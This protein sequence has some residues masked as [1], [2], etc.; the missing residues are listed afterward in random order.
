MLNYFVSRCNKSGFVGLEKVASSPPVI[1]GAEMILFF[2]PLSV[3][4]FFLLTG[5]ALLHLTGEFLF[6]PRASATTDRHSY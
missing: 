3:S 4:G 2:W 5:V 6:Y 1:Y